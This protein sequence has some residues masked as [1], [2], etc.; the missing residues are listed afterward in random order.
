MLDG[1]PSPTPAIIRSPHKPTTPAN[2]KRGPEFASFPS[3]ARPP[4]PPTPPWSSLGALADFTRQLDFVM[5]SRRPLGGIP[6][7]ETVVVYICPATEVATLLI[8]KESG[9]NDPEAAPHAR[10][11][12][13]FA[14]VVQP[15]SPPARATVIACVCCSSAIQYHPLRVSL[16]LAACVGGSCTLA[17]KAFSRLTVATEFIVQARELLSQAAHDEH[18]VRPAVWQPPNRSAFVDVGYELRLRPYVVTFPPSRGTADTPQGLAI[19]CWSKSSAVRVL[20]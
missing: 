20:L 8:Q 12:P 15:T 7:E 17:P 5:V 6:A 1:P 4:S 3:T 19:D 11:N 10:S 18:F 9:V 16:D 2:D 13:S 14:L